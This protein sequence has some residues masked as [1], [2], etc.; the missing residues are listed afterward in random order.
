MCGRFSLAKHKE[1]IRAQFPYIDKGFDDI[2][3]KIRYNIAPGQASA[4]ITCENGTNRIRMF[5]WGLIPSW[6]KDQKTGYSMINAR[7]ETI[8]KKTSFRKLLDKG[9]CL[10]IADGFYEWLR[11]GSGKKVPYRIIVSNRECFT[12]AGLWDK[13]HGENETLYTFTIITCGANTLVESIHDRMPVILPAANERIWLNGVINTG[14]I[15][16]LLVP[17]DPSPME[18]FRVSTLVN[19]WKNDVPQCMEKSD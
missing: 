18:M 10:V 4:V 8:E 13:W 3:L 6:S 12:F 11:T 9:R 5:R 14:E 1:D 17:Y 7:A 19:S 2:D 15:K 16:E